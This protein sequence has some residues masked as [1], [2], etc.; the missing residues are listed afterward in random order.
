MS[1]INHGSLTRLDH[2]VLGVDDIDVST[3]WYEK[4]LGLVP[5]ADTGGRTY[6]T[7]PLGE[8]IVLGLSSG[9]RGLRRY[10]VEALNREMLD[11]I[12]ST[13]R[14]A[15]IR[16][17]EADDQRPGASGAVQFALPSGH[18]MECL[19]ASPTSYQWAGQWP[20]GATPL[21][22]SHVQIRCPD[23]DSLARFMTDLGFLVSDV[24]ASP[25]GVSLATFVRVHNAHHTM[26]ILEG[27]RAGFHHV[28]F[29]VSSSDLLPL[30]DRVAR[31]GARLEYGPGRHRPGN[32]LFM[33]V[34]D[35]SGNRVELIADMAHL[36]PNTPP[37]VINESIDVLVNQWGPQPPSS[38]HSDWV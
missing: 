29:E 7:D 12:T 8:R 16:V 14:D 2:V 4:V 30:A 9:G 38:W 24:I 1:K 34:L 33:Y 17:E 21:E 35:P 23:S 11:Q 15:G 3:A 28:A 20:I 31:A 10:S 26:S 6:L 27:D 13:L 18:T 19:V 22:I 5:I 36:T 32:N 25:E 37:T